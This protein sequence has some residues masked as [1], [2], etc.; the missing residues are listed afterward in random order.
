[1]ITAV[2]EI[3]RMLGWRITDFRHIILGSYPKPR[4]YQTPDRL[5][6]ARAF[7][8]GH[9]YFQSLKRGVHAQEGPLVQPPT[10]PQEWDRREW[11]ICPEEVLR[12]KQEVLRGNR[13]CRK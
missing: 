2:K 8:P 10:Q 3:N 1:M 7:G 11:Q 9:S 12:G 6:T 4:D 13:K 5:L